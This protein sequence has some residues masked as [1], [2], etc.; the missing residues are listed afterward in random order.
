MNPSSSILTTSVIKEKPSQSMNRH[1][2]LARVYHTAQLTAKASDEVAKL[3][4]SHEPL[5]PEDEATISVVTK[6]R[7]DQLRRARRIITVVE[8]RE[9]NKGKV[10]R[11]IALRGFKSK[12]EEELAGLLNQYIT[13]IDNAFL[14]HPT[15]EP[16]RI[17]FLKMKADYCRYLAEIGRMQP[18]QV[19]NA[20]VAAYDAA[21]TSLG[22]AHPLRT[23]IALNFS[24]FYFEILKNKDAAIQIAKMAHDEGLNAAKTLPIDEKDDA[25]E[26]LNLINTNLKNWI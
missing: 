10:N 19:Q 8:E 23:G 20:Y 24:V 9:E 6:S 2:F 1:S 12:V 15:S 3:A 4:V 13:N 26:V 7:V 21:R 11:V 25:M 22:P 18:N 5:T 17:L 16:S 14:V